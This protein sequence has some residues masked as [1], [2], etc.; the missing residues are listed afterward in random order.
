VPKAEEEKLEE[1]TKT[2]ADTK[3]K[4]EDLTSLSVQVFAREEEEQKMPELVPKDAPSFTLA[5]KETG[6]H[7]GVFVG[8]FPTLPAKPDAPEAK[9]A[10]TPERLVYVAYSDKRTSS[11]AGEWAVSSQLEVVAGSKGAHEVIEMQDTQLDRRSELEKGV[12]MGKLARVY[13]DLGL[14][15]DARRAFDEALKVVKA[16]V[17]AE[18]GSPLGEEATYQMWDLYFASG[19]EEAAAEACSKLIATFPNSPLADDALLIMGKAEKKNIHAA[20]GHFSRLVQQYPDS[21][22]APEAAYLFADLK[23]KAGA[24]DVAAFE[25]VANK[26]PDSNF[27]AQGLLR[28]SEYYIENKDFA[29]AKDYLERIALDFPDFN[30]LDKV[31]Y[32]RGI[33]AY[34]SGDVQLAYTLMHETIEKYPG[35]SVANSASKVVELLARKLKQ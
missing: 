19:D 31:T 11:H 23:S 12:A 13:M 6:E 10:L 27:A 29:R 24:F 26:Y 14:R 5:L 17:D 15:V 2:A 30:S 25:Q 28:L 16:V 18:R 7:T 4:A 22:L 34:R 9:L 8:S 33:C 21:D 32:M 1:G 3:E 20:M 35:T